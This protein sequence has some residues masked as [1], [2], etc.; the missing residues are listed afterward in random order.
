VSDV[1]PY[2]HTHS[3]VVVCQI[4]GITSHDIIH[5]LQAHPVAG[6]AASYARFIMS[7]FQQTPSTGM[8]HLSAAHDTVVPPFGELHVHDTLLHAAGNA[9]FDGV[10][11]PGAQNVSAPYVVAALGYDLFA[12][13]H[14]GA[15]SRFAVHDALAHPFTPAHVQ[16]SDQPTPGKAVFELLPCA[17]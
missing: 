3:Y 13:P 4:H 1:H 8:F 10:A 12:V 6:F 9:G 15:G 14:T 17:H 2:C 5:Q 7:R 16:F 11:E